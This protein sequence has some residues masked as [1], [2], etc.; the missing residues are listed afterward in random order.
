MCTNNTCVN[1]YWSDIGV[2]ESGCCFY[3]KSYINQLNYHVNLDVEA[4]YR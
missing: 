2:K 3:L 1:T 4:Y